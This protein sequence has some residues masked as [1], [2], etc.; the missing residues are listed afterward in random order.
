MLDD[1][2]PRVAAHAG[3]CLCNCCEK[4]EQD[5]LQPYLHAIISK[6]YSFLIDE[7]V[8]N[9]M[10]ESILSGLGSLI[11]AAKGLPI[12][13]VEPMMN[14]LLPG[15]PKMRHVQFRQIRGQ[16]LEC[17]SILIASGGPELFRPYMNAIV[18]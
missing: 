13:Y 1:P 9:I 8:S 10:K 7:K 6:G 16:T 15:L 11:N 5:S 2:V 4:L 12:P 18:L 17:I 14:I 3:A